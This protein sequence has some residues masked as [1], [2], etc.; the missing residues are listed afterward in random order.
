MKTARARVGEFEIAPIFDGTIVSGLDKIPNQEDRAAAA[1]LTGA[2]PGVPIIIDVYGFLVRGPEGLALIDAG[3]GTTKGPATGRFLGNLT[4]AGVSA[5]AIDRIYM[6]HWHAD[7]FGGL[8]DEGGEA[9]FPNAELIVTEPEAR[10]W[11]ETPRENMPAR[12]Q[13][14]FEG[15][16][17]ALAPYRTRLRIVPREGVYRGL[18]AIASPGHTPGH[19][20]WL[21]SSGGSSALAWGDV[22]HIAPI[23]LPR[24]RTGFE[25]DLDAV[26]AGETRVR[27]L[28]LAARERMLIAGAHLDAPGLGYIVKEGDAFRIEPAGLDEGNGPV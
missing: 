26:L 3:S 11:F 25:Y 8:I 16:R 27:I 15:A 19:T 4:A 23:H 2:G 7:H 22:V 1:D 28:E 17:A 10:F 18:A 5:A 21:I 13:R 6:T 12:A 24:P 14:A 9:V 20:C